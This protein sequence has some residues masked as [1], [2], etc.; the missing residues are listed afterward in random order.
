MQLVHFECDCLED[1]SYTGTE[2]TTT[3][4]RTAQGKGLQENNSF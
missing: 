3:I 4:L 2:E 1:C